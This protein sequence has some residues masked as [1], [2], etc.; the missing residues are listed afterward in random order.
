MAEATPNLNLQKPERG[1]QDWDEPLRQTI[2]AL[3]DLQQR[4]RA[5]DHG[6]NQVNGVVPQA[7]YWRAAIA[8]PQDCGPGWSTLT[9]W[10]E[11]FVGGFAMS[12]SP[13]N[14][15]PVTGMITLGRGIYLV[16]AWAAGETQQGSLWVRLEHGQIWFGQD[17]TVVDATTG[18]VTPMAVIPIDGDL[19]V[20]V[21]PFNNPPDIQP[22][23]AKIEIIQLQPTFYD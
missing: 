6:E 21:Q 15:D 22:V 18:A 12:F 4:H 7:A 3:D 19:H 13:P 14:V 8:T 16:R 20:T 11:Q 9:G 1:E 23:V 17:G 2:D 5:W 10:V